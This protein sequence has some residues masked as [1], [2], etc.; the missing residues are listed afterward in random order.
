LPIDTCKIDPDLAAAV[1]AWPELPETL[2]TGIVALVRA[3]RGSA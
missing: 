2:K 3:A 1:A